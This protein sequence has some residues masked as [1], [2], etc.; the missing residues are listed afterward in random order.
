MR[1]IFE[2]IAREENVSREE[3]IEEIRK[4]IRIS[5]SSDTPYAKAF[6]AE[7]APDGK[8]PD[9]EFAL[10]AIAERFKQEQRKKNKK[11]IFP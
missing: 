6:W 10:T 8:E 7:V 5:M 11:K 4:A 3:V 9:P 2:E 1:D